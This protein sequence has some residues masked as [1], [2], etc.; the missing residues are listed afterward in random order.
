MRPGNGVSSH[1]RVHANVLGRLGIPR[2]VL[3][4]V[5][6]ECGPLIV[7]NETH[8]LRCPSSALRSP[9]FNWILPVSDLVLSTFIVRV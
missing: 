9:L 1:P 7:G 3:P 5:I 4:V 8:P 6:Q 2:S